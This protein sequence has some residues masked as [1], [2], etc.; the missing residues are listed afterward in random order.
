MS[1]LPTLQSFPE[2]SDSTESV[3]SLLIRKHGARL[4]GVRVDDVVAFIGVSFRGLCARVGP[5]VV[6]LAV[7]ISI[8]TEHVAHL[9]TDCEEEIARGRKGCGFVAPAT[10]ETPSLLR[11]SVTT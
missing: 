11:L 4:T 3:K 2:A 7:P 10:R 1:V 5:A 8:I 9:L 6:A